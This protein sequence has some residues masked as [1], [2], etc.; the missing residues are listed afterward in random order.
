VLNKSPEEAEEM[1]R[2]E[3]LRTLTTLLSHKEHADWH[4]LKDEE[5]R[6][7]VDLLLTLGKEMREWIALPRAER[8]GK[9]LKALAK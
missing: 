3:V 1:R 8:T 4:T 5:A 6:L 9:K 7:A 2:Q